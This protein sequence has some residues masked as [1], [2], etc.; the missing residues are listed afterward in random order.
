MLVRY[1]RVAPGY[2]RTLDAPSSRAA[3]S[4]EHGSDGHVPVTVISEELARALADRFGIKDSIGQIVRL[5]SLGYDDADKDVN[6]QVVGVIRGERVQ[7][8]L[9]LPSN[10]SPTSR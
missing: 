2:F 7:R 10:P 1:K 3:S 9:R 8:N 5:P 4:R 6:M